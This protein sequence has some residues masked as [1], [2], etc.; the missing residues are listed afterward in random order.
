MLRPAENFDLSSSVVDFAT[1]S[2][3]PLMAAQPRPEW[4]EAQSNRRQTE[5]R[6][7]H[8][9]RWEEEAFQIHLGGAGVE[10]VAN[11]VSAV[12]MTTPSPAGSALSKDVAALQRLVNASIAALLLARWVDSGHFPLS[13]LYESLLFL[14]WSITAVQ[15]YLVDKNFKVNIWLKKV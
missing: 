15:I 13:N 6:G 2:M 3:R 5:S 1:P 8:S 11:S 12:L 4:E 9:R 10:S 14:A 7:M